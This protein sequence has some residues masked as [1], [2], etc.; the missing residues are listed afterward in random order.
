MTLR[1]ES[2]ASLAVT[3]SLERFEVATELF[4]TSMASRTLAHE[5]EGH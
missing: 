3:T 4:L 5:N 1:H 2:G